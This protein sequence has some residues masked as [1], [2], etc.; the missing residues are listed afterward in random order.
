MRFVMIDLADKRLSPTMKLALANY[1]AV[2]AV[3]PRTTDPAVIQVVDE[4]L[5]KGPERH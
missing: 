2:I 1:A 4:A 5:G 3:P